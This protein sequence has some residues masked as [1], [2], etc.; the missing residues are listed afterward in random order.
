MKRSLIWALLGE[1]R[2][3]GGSVWRMQGQMHKALIY[4]PESR[5]S[6]GATIFALSMDVQNKHTLIG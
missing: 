3:T 2:V 4:L 5:L 6:Q 1:R